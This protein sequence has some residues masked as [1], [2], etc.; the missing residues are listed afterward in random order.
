MSDT[1]YHESE[2]ST[3][4]MVTSLDKEYIKAHKPNPYALV[5]L[6]TNA[7][8]GQHAIRE[9]GID[10]GLLDGQVLTQ[11]YPPQASNGNFD[12]QE[13]DNPMEEDPQAFDGFDDI[14][15]SQ[16][17]DHMMKDPQALDGFDD[18]FGSQEI[19]FMEGAPQN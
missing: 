8:I 10:N 7:A 6:L 11:E 19:E 17:F 4:L 14:F 9:Y 2:L 12:S 3:E 18:I 5:R 1:T 13:L 15:G 16:E